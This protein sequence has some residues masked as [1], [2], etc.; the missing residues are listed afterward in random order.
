MIQVIQKKV[1]NEQG[2]FRKWKICVDQIFGIIM[3]AEEY[4]GKDRNLYAAFMNLEKADDG[5]DGE[6]LW[7][8]LKTKGVRGKLI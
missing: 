1:G 2:D 5:D 7:N 3:L 4:L 6:A 8:V